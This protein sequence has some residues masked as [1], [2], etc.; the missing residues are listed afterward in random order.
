MDS[1]LENME[2]ILFGNEAQGSNSAVCWDS[3]SESPGLRGLRGSSDSLPPRVRCIACPSPEEE[4]DCRVATK[5]LPVEHTVVKEQ[6]LEFPFVSHSS[7]GGGTGV[8]RNAAL[9]M[10]KPQGW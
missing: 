8:Q 6:H 1:N 10:T 7:W 2:W 9:C 3:G 5:R 4:R